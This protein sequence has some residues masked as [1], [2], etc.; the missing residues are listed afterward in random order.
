MTGLDALIIVIA[1]VESGANPH[2]P[3]GDHGQAHGMYQ[4]HRA[5]W[6][7]GCKVLG[8]KWPFPADAYDPAK[9]RRVVVA[10][11][12]RYCGPSASLADY[13]RCHNGGLNWIKKPATLVYLDKIK[14]EWRQHYK[15]N[16]G[17]VP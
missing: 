8:V 17:D 5:Y 16:F 15:L 10:Y 11:L 9:A 1:I 3:V 2:P 7:D 12:T 6:L 13:A 4:I 14:V